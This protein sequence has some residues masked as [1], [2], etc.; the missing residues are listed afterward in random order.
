MEQPLHVLERDVEELRAA[1]SGAMPS[2]GVI[3]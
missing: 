2:S 3:G 1:W